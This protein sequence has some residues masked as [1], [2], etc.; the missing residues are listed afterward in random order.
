MAAKYDKKGNYAGYNKNN[1]E[2]AMLDYYSTPVEEVT[3]ILNK[4]NIDFSYSTILEPS[5]GG[6]HMVKGIEDYLEQNPSYAN[7]VN[8]IA[9]D[10]AKRDSKYFKDSFLTG[11]EYDFLPD[12]YPIKE[13]V[14]WVIMNP[15]YAT[16]E[17]FTIKSLELAK[18]GVILLARLQFLE[19][20]SRYE[21]IFKEI[22]PTDVYI[23][24]DRISCKK[25]GNEEIKENSVQCYAWILF[26][27][28][29]PKPCELHWITSKNYK[30]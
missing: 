27:K 18:K 7:N 15:P 22:Q 12:T 26:D 28:Q 24:V 19:S 10:V 4:L 9:T 20:Q 21:H 29:N 11:E 14:D 6:G 23:Y 3:N 17:Y 1:K 16:I 5:C 30:N 8:I 25:N 13:G 2:R